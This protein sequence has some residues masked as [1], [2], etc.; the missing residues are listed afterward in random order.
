[1]TRMLDS[2]LPMEF[3]EGATAEF[4]SKQ[5]RRGGPRFQCPTGSAPG[6][7]LGGMLS[8]RAGPYKMAILKT[9]SAV[10]ELDDK[11]ES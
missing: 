11:R 1:M 8:L 7:N 10:N 4:A 3:G 2:C 5:S 9:E 6:G